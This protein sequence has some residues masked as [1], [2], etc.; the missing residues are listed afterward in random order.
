M[1]VESV[2]GGERGVGEDFYGAVTGGEEDC[3]G[4]TVGGGVGEEGLVCLEGLR[5]WG[6]EGECWAGDREESVVLWR[7]MESAYFCSGS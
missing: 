7:E 2:E 6:A 5:M 1:C 3:L 4:R